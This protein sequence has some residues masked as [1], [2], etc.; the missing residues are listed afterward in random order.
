MGRIDDGWR[1]QEVR[2]DDHETLECVNTHAHDR[3][4]RDLLGEMHR[5]GDERH[6]RT[7]GT[8]NAVR[9]S[10]FAFGYTNAPRVE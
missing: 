2:D 1:R 3:R 7:K 5:R 8:R 4:R 6:R 10:H 9:V